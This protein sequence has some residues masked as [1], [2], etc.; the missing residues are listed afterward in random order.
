L[1]SDL[2]NKSEAAL[3]KEL[4]ETVTQLESIAMEE[5]LEAFVKGAWHV[6][7]PGKELHWNW[8]MT[9]VCL[10]LE[11]FSRREFHRG[12]INIPPRTSKSII[13]SVLFQIWIW[14]QT[15]TDENPFVGPSH[16]FLCLSNEDGLA[17]RDAVKARDL[18]ESEW[19]QARWGKRVIIP[20]GQSEK[21][22]YKTSK[23]GHR[24]SKS[25]NGKLTGRGGDTICIDDPHDAEKAL[26]EVSRGSDLASY[27]GKV[28][29]RLNDQ[30]NGGILIIMQRLHELDLTGYVLKKDGSWGPDN[31][32]GW[33]KLCLPMEFVPDNPKK[34][35]V[36]PA[37]VLG[38]IDKRT[39]KGELLDIVRFPVDVITKLKAAL[40]SYRSSGQFQQEPSPDDGGILK[41]SWWKLW[42]EKRPFPQCV[43]IVQS[44]DTAFTAKDHDINENEAS[45]SISYSARTTWGVFYSEWTG[46]YC[47]MLIEAWREQCDYPTL[48]K[49]AKRAYLAQEPDA[50]LIEKK[51]SGQSLIQDL[52][53]AS[54]PVI[55]TIPVLD[56]IARAYSVQPVLESGLIY[57]PDRKWAEECVDDIGKFPNG[58]SAD[59]TDTATQAWERI[60]RNFLVSHPEDNPEE[61][62]IDDTPKV[63]EGGAAYG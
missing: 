30:V 26:S 27:S 4:E 48:R 35:P 55:T 50:V 36:N 12:V 37:A 5:S 53:K 47:V 7:E 54:I 43:Y 29:S 20:H 3:L 46:R 32:Y 31:K 21:K 61:N 28:T 8:H 18:I 16:E 41:K 10:F 45:G 42:P 51:A 33:L 15:K 19:F 6:I 34:L 60:R 63:E 13:V 56:K 22:M 44:Y 58:A 57:Y 9:L 24:N 17:L 40:G 25:L 14:I 2:T 49:E 38:F 52:R 39:K 11:S 1:P 23:N 59:W 62:E